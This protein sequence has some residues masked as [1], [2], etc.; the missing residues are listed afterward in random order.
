MGF[1]KYS[2]M[3]EFKKVKSN[4][5]DKSIN[6]SEWFTL[7]QMELHFVVIDNFDVKRRLQLSWDNRKKDEVKILARLDI[8]Y[9]PR[10]GN[11]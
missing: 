7:E 6:Q 3:V 2:K 4:E 5:C 1:H 11:G 8:F 10:K 9:V